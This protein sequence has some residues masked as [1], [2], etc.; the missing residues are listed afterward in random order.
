MYFTKPFVA[1]ALLGAAAAQSSS[2]TAAAAAAS[3]STVPTH[4][5]MVGGTNGSLTYSPDNVVANVGDLVQFQF[6][7]KVG[8][9]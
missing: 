5:I 6:M 9:R 4:V 8:R 1:F 3:G 2:S 7:P